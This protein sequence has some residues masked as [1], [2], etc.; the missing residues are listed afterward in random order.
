MSTVRL[1]PLPTTKFPPDE[2]F[3]PSRG[4]NVP[5]NLRY[6]DLNFLNDG[7]TV[8]VRG[9]EH[10]ATGRAGRIYLLQATIAVHS[11]A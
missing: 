5:S 10:W 11:D 6:P 2:F 9:F 8:L 3:T 1:P 4:N 7:R